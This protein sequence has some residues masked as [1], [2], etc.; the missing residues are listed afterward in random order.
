MISCTCV[1]GFTAVF[2]DTAMLAKFADHKARLESQIPAGRFAQPDDVA[3]VA[4]FL[5]S[6]G[7]G[8]ITG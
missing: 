8:Y 1:A 3:Q 7:A 2:I 5:F 4:A 6:P